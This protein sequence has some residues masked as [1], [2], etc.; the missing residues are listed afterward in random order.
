MKVIERYIFGRVSS[1]FLAALAWSL[2][3]VWTTQVL[4][5]ID[6]VTDSG[7][8]AL[9]FFEIATLVL[10]TVIPLVIPF[11]LVVGVTQT[12]ATMNTDSELA[13]ISASGASR[14]TVI[15]P[16][17]LLAVLASVASFLVDNIVEPLARVRNRELIAESRGDLISLIIQ[18]GT[19]RKVDDGL[20]VQV[21]K[22]LADGNLGEIFV[23]DSREKDVDMTYYAKTG[24]VTK[25]NGNNQLLMF[26]GVVNRKEVGKDVSLIRFASYAFDLGG[27]QNAN[28]EILL[29]PKDRSLFYLMNP[30]PNDRIFQEFPQGYR[31]EMHRRLTEW[32][33]PL[34][35]ALIALAVAGD[36]KSHRQT[37]IHPMVTAGAIALFWWWICYF[38]ADQAEKTPGLIYAM[39]GVPLLSMTLSTWII[40]TNRSVDAPIS[41]VEW[42]GGRVKRL[43]SP[44]LKRLPFRTS[45]SGAS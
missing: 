7:Q 2:A 21:G 44:I 12:L 14:M 32:A 10:P 31:A 28:K 27:F 22:R 37:N 20:F 35:F 30:D 6:I 23:A 18:E 45:E 13:V 25:I 15:K 41:A 17:M 43:A 42:V 38:V 33:F 36:A 19:F 8:T 40:A 26:D 9:T 1:V 11:A 24:A 5:K 16:I 4:A 34:V 3:I 29:L 39:Y